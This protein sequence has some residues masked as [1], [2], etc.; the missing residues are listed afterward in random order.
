MER[1]VITNRNQVWTTKQY[2]STYI[3]LYHAENTLLLD[4]L[5]IQQFYFFRQ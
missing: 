3:H 4:G 2:T 5:K 1:I